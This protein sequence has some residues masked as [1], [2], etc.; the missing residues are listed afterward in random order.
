MD[1]NISIDKNSNYLFNATKT[2][3][4]LTAIGLLKK[5]TD[6]VKLNLLVY[7]FS[8]LQLVHQ[9]VNPLEI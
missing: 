6:F 2:D 7:M 4:T 8:K 1:S 5:S 9:S 3:I